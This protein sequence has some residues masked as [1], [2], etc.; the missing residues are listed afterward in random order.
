M[1][2]Q[3]DWDSETGSL[4]ISTPLALTGRLAW[5]GPL[6]SQCGSVVLLVMS[7]RCCGSCRRFPKRT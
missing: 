5:G 3:C 2:D 1:P 4:A 7:S 6:R